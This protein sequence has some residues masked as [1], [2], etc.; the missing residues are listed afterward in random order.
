[1]PETAVVFPGQ[2][3][4]AVGMG[5]DVYE[6]S[7]AG[8]AV[9]QLADRALSFSLSEI[10]FSGPEAKLTETDISQPAILVT[11]MALVEAAREAGWNALS[12][13]TAGLSLGEYTALVFAGCLALEDAIT[14]VHRRGTYMREAGRKNP[15]GMLSVIGLDEAVITEIV[16]AASAQGVISAANL[17]CPGQI[18]LSGQKPALEAA[19]KLASERGAMKTAF[20]KVDGAFHSPLMQEAAE[21]LARDLAS[22]KIVAPRM[23]FVANVTGEVASDPETIRRHLAAQVT[24]TVLW[25]KSVRTILALGVTGFTEIG[26]GRVLTGLT[27]RIDRRIAAGAVGDMEQAA[28]LASA[29]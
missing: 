22:V 27:R 7:K 17:N 20:L 14:L 6:K 26:P 23:P 8:R 1:M 9:F 29:S 3:A 15:G 21:R 28:A 5:R 25:E 10:V 13:A 19:E 24:S 2:G 18:V 16:K 4:Q 11:S 12:A